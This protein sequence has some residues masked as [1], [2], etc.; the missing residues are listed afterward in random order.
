MAIVVKENEESIEPGNHGI[1]IWGHYK[2]HAS[3]R[4]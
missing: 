1:L 4:I 2:E 3:G